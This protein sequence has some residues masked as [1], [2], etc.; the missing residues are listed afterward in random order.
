MSKT[1]YVA[2]LALAVLGFVA[3]RLGED[4]ITNAML[5]LIGVA[6]TG[7][8]LWYIRSTQSYAERNPGQALLEGAEFLEWSKLEA[9]AKGVPSLPGPQALIEIKSGAPR[10]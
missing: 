9:A 5:M 1:S 7:F 10:A 6:A 4:Q 8:A 3:W 2:A